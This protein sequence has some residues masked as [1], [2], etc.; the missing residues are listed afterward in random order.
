MLPAV[1]RRTRNMLLL[2]VLA[3]PGPAAAQVERMDR[4]AFPAESDSAFVQGAIRGREVAD[5]VVSAAP[6]QRVQAELTASNPNVFLNVRAP[7]SMETTHVGPV[8]GNVFDGLA[9]AAGDY[10]LSVFLVGE[11]ARRDEVAAYALSVT[12][13][14][15]QPAARP[16]PQQAAE[17]PPAA[18]PPRPEA[19][20]ITGLPRGQTLNL[21]GGPSTRDRVVARLAAREV[22]LGRGC[23][24]VQAE[25]WCQVERQEGGGAGWVMA[26][27]LAPA[28]LPTPASL[29]V[30]AAAR[31]PA[32]EAE[33]APR[34]TGGFDAVGFLPC[35]MVRGQPSREC[36]FGVERAGQG[37]ALLD[38]LGANGVTRRIVF[39]R[40]A[41]V[42][43][44]GGGPLSV[45]RF[46]DL[47]LIRLGDE[48]FEVP[49]AVVTGG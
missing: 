45:E 37:A 12:V 7:G 13:A 46:G 1:L 24:Q 32:R 41:P 29:A 11:A 43:A 33:T 25:R 42:R 34:R 44:D 39:E 18:A 5:Y 35:A 47:F 30:P 38:V 20:A 2:V 36:R 15:R 3:W 10:R 22:V 16:E 49:E 21:R 8:R 26:R 27:Y 6:G 19:F 4:I 48:R 17:A 23:Q 14:P 40:G 31:A 28:A 9:T